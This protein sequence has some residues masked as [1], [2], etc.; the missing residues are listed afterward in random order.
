MAVN[1]GDLFVYTHA[2][3][4]GYGEMHLGQPLSA[5]MQEL[6]IKEGQEVAFLE[7]DA[8]SGW[9]IVEWVDDKGLD[10]ITTIDPDIFDTNFIPR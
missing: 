4:K 9:P 3:G 2:D 8:E 5:E 1:K 6:D 10:R 7:Y